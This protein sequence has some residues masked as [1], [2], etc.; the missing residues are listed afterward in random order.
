MIANDYI[1]DVQHEAL[2]EVKVRGLPVAL[3]KTPGVV[4]P[5]APEFG[6]HTEEVLIDIA[7]YTWEE[8]ADLKDKEVI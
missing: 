1:I 7:G 5:V 3:S 4:N 8:I 2:G 6:Q